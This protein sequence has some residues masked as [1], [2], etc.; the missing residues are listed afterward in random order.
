MKN[1]SVDKEKCIQEVV[2]LRAEEKCLRTRAL[3]L[4]QVVQNILLRQPLNPL[5]ELDFHVLSRH[6]EACPGRL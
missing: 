5:R 6:A 4:P 2:P 1:E 3:E